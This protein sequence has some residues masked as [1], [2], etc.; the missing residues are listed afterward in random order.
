ML[1]KKNK[2]K[3][4]RI[5]LGGLIVLRDNEPFGMNELPGNEA[6]NKKK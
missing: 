5:L 1:T 6:S 3:Q 2:S 4:G